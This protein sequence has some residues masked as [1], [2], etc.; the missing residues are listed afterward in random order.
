MPTSVIPATVPASSGV[1]LEVHRDGVV[2]PRSGRRVVL[3]PSSPDAT[4]Q[5]IQGT[6]SSLVSNRFAVLADEDPLTGEGQ[7]EFAESGVSDHGRMAFPAQVSANRPKR[8]RVVGQ[9]QR[10][11]QATTIPAPSQSAVDALE[12]DLI[13]GESSGTETLR[14]N[15]SDEHGDVI[16]DEDRASDS[17]REDRWEGAQAS[18]SDEFVES[19]DDEFEVVQARISTDIRCALRDLDE[20]NLED[21]FA[22][23]AKASLIF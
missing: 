18:G 1:L 7:E 14:H 6:P 17:A 12:F 9:F 8:L 5:S 15:S 2:P 4:L 13:R 19:T 3:V 10:G 11:S 20:V 21:E 22:H 23:A 16:F